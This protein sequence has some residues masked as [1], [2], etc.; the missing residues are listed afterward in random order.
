MPMPVTE[1]RIVT[2]K[3]R[4]RD[5]AELRPRRLDELIGQE[6]VVRQLRIAIQ[7]AK[8]RGECLDHVLFYGPPGCLHGDTPIYDPVAQTTMTVCDRWCDGVPFHVHAMAADGQICVAEAE[9]P[10]RYERADM[11]RVTMASGRSFTATGAHRIWDG[12][13]WISVSLLRG[14]LKA[15]GPVPVRSSSLDRI[16]EV[17]EVGASHYYV[18]HVP[19]HENYLAVGLI[20]HNTG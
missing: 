9:A 4:F 10:W 13:K 8:E 14:L 5:R 6:G 15:F 12:G 2:N 11:M 1:E 18:F 16:K 17:S 19:V 7:A 3:K 20:H